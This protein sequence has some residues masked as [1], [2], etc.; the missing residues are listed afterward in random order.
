MTYYTIFYY[1]IVG[2]IISYHSPAEL[3]RSLYLAAGTSIMRMDNNND[4]KII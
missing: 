2:Y 1:V 3:A 4:D